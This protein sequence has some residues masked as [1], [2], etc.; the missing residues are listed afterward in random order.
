[1]LKFKEIKLLNWLK[2]KG[3]TKQH[4]T[5]IAFLLCTF[6]L[7]II[8]MLSGYKGLKPKKDSNNE[9]EII[10]SAFEKHEKLLAD[11]KN[12]KDRLEQEKDNQ[13]NISR[14]IPDKKVNINLALEDELIDLPEIG[15]A[16][17]EK[18]I[19][20]REQAGKFKSIEEIMNV[21][22]IGQKKFEKLRDYITIE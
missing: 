7:G 2:N 1:M 10:T 4:I 15:P 13:K 17:A 12:N 3:F 11:I 8:L 6:S 22:G 5:V 21:K 16:T 9:K 14:K 19:A 20:Y 18:I